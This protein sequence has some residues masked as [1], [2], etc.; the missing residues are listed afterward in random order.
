MFTLFRFT[1]RLYALRKLLADDVAVAV[2]LGLL[3]SLAIM[4]QYAIP[5]MFEIIAVAEGREEVTSSLQDRGAVYLKLQ[6]AIIVVF[7]SEIWA[8]KVC[9][10]MF[11]RSLFTGLP[12]HMRGWWLA[13]GLTVITYILCWGFQLGS[14]HPI[15]NYFILGESQACCPTPLG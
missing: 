9:F 1:V 10:L 7:W 4:Y 5:P 11:Y 15:P 2:A 6:F 12:E 14:C 3:L 13:V 8:V